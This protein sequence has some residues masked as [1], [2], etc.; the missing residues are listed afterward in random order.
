MFSFQHT[1][2]LVFHQNP[3][4]ISF[5]QQ[6]R[7]Q[8]D[9][10]VKL[11]DHVPMEAT[12]NTDPL[13]KARKLQG[14]QSSSSKPSKDEQTQRKLA[15]REIERQRRRDMA[16]LYASIRCLLPLEFVKGKR[17]TSDHILQ[18]MNYIKH[19]QEK[20][21]VLSF[22]RDRLK[23]FVEAGVP[24]PSTYTEKKRLMNLRHNTVLISSCDEGVQILVNS[25]SIEDGF[26]LSRVLKAIS[27]EGYNVI[28][29]SCTKIN[30]RLIHSI[31]TEVNGLVSTDISMLQHKLS[32]VANNY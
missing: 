1:D 12:T 5:Q 20:I 24:G 29:C 8:Q 17:S 9:L 13:T 4:T 11:H 30:Q 7:N 21:E 27:D 22:K 26:P 6:T 16:E 23:K 15:H 28:S 3:Y 19:L 14:G 25:C 31:Q 32:A 10:V 2:D 18:A